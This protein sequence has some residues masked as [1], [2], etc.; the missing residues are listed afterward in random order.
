MPIVNTRLRWYRTSDGVDVGESFV[1]Q[2]G[3]TYVTAPLNRPRESAAAELSFQYKTTASTTG[4]LTIE[5]SDTPE[6]AAIAGG[7]ALGH[8]PGC[9]WDDLATSG[10]TIPAIA[11]AA[12]NTLR[13]KKCG[14]RGRLK[15]VAGATGGSMQADGTVV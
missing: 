10:P 13:T 7:G 1:P 14:K 15:F 3:V 5:S 4:T 2:N 9:N 11:G 8:A 6:S 12:Q